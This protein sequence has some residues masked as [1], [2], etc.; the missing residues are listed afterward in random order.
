MRESE[1]DHCVSQKHVQLN[2]NS[3]CSDFTLVIVGITSH[4]P[5]L[6][7]SMI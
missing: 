7:L 3:A 4:K 2:L 1:T 6:R 5:L